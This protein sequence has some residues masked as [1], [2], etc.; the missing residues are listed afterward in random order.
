[1]RG[2]TKEVV[3]RDRRVRGVG[4]QNERRPRGRRDLRSQT[5]LR[6]SARKMWGKRA[7]DCGSGSIRSFRRV[8]FQSTKNNSAKWNKRDDGGRRERK[9]RVS[10]DATRSASAISATCS[11]TRVT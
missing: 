3:D 7:D 6:V 10:R 8:V 11:P 4:N 5:R 1:M 9:R 2:Q